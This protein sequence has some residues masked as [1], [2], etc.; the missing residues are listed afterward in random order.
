[1]ISFSNINLYGLTLA[2][3]VI[4]CF[5][6]FQK[7]ITQKKDSLDLD[8]VA[9]LFF[10]LFLGAI[11]FGRL[12][13]VFSFW[14]FFYTQPLEIFKLWHGGIAFYGVFSGGLLGLLFW[15]KRFTQKNKLNFKNYL[16]FLL[17]SILVV[18]PLGQSIGRWGN[19]FNQELFGS[20]TSLP[21]GIF[22][23]PDNRPSIFSS[24]THFHPV[25]LYESILSFCLFIYSES[26]T[27]KKFRDSSPVYSSSSTGSFAFL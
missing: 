9:D 12:F 8:Q 11:L 25:F 1:M 20:P 13:F 7:I 5:Y 18:L 22:I 21:W 14:H 6:I 10:Y 4:A 26:I 17:D 2:I 27:E 24:Q 23:S 16:I 3:A 15:T 19:F